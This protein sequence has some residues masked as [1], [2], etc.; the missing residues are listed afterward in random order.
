MNRLTEDYIRNIDIDDLIDFMEANEQVFRETAIKLLKENNALYVEYELKDL[1]KRSFFPS[2]NFDIVNN[3]NIFSYN[4]MSYIEEIIDSYSSS[5]T[6]MLK[7]I[8]GF[9]K[10]KS[11]WGKEFGIALLLAAAKVQNVNFLKWVL[12]QGVSVVSEDPKG[13]DALTYSLDSRQRQNYKYETVKFLLSN[14]EKQLHRREN[15]IISK[16][17][18]EG[19][20]RRTYLDVESAWEASDGKI[21]ALL[22]KYNFTK[23]N[24]F[25]GG[26]YL[27]GKKIYYTYESDEDSDDDY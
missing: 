21:I 7:E 25:Y 23:R 6:Q 5:K 10:N 15:K 17:N 13:K 27:N 16:T 22:K 26:Y 2:G 3:S 1:L 19:Y 14:Y 12:S 24:Y 4:T 9:V 8:Y 18:K 20:P 11:C